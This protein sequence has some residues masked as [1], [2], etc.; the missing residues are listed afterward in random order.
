MQNRKSGLIANLTFRRLSHYIVR[1]LRNTQI[2][3]NQITAFRL[4]LA[5]SAAPFLIIGKEAYLLLGGIISAASFTFDYV[6]GDL[7]RQKQLESKTGQLL[8]VLFDRITIIILVFSLSLGLFRNTMTL[9]DLLLGIMIISLLYM[10][11]IIDTLLEK[12]FHSSFR[13]MYRLEIDSVTGFLR[14]LGFE[15]EQ[16][17]VY[18]FGEDFLYSLIIIGIVLNVVRYALLLLL[19]YTSGLVLLSIIKILKGHMVK[20]VKKAQIV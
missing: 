2:T 12:I 18:L 5:F 20:D 1:F 15:S 11:E 4:I 16:T 9:F 14:R 17:N 10:S 6:D 13:D 19:L 3:P 8:D 7:A